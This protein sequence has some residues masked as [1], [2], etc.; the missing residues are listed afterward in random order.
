[1]ITVKETR[2]TSRRNPGLIYAKALDRHNQIEQKLAR[3]MNAWQKSRAALKRLE[4]RL[5]E[6][7]MD[8]AQAKAFDEAQAFI[9]DPI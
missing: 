4:K 6:A 5:D 7:A 2:P 3:Y 8:E 1:M 9:D